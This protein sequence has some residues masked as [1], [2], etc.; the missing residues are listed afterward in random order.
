MKKGILG[1]LFAL[2]VN[3]IF[4]QT[5]DIFFKD[6]VSRTW[7]AEDGIQ[8]NSI[9][10][11]FQDKDGYILFGTYGGLTRFDGVKFLT[12]N[13]IYNKDYK[14]LS[15]RTIFQDSRGNIWVGSN[16]EGAFCI[17][18]E[19]G[20]AEFTT[21]NG[22]PNNSIRSFCEDN[23]GNIWIGTASGIACVSPDLNIIKLPGFDKIPLDNKF[24]TFQL[25][26]DT[27]GRI[28]IV[29]RSEKGLYIY[30]DQTFTVYDGIH[31]VENPV[32]TAMSQDST[33]AFWFG[34]APYYA[35]KVT[36]NKEALHNL[37]SGDQKGTIVTCIYQDSSKNIWFGLDNGITILHDGEYSYFKKENGLSDESVVKIIEDKEKNIWIATDRGGIQKLS[38]GKF[39]TTSMPTT[40]NAIAQDKYR[41]VVWLAGDNGMYCYKDNKLQENEI[42]KYC[43]N[44]RIRHVGVTK[45]N[46]VLVSTYEKF[47]QL[48]FNADGTIDC[49]TKE[50]GL[51]GNRVRVAE[52]MSNGDLYVGTTTGLSIISSKTGEIT[53]I[54]KGETLKN[55]YIMCLYEAADG[56]IWAGTDG[57]GIFIL[58][59]TQIERII[60]KEDFLAG[61]VVFK[62]AGYNNNDIWITTGTGV[63]LYR[64]EKIH[65]FNNSNGFGS[66]GVFQ[67]IPDFSGR[68]WGTSN[69]GIFFVKNSEIEEVIAGTRNAVNIKYFNRLDG[70]TSGGVTSTS[71]SMKDDLGRIWFTLIDGFT[72][73][74]PVRNASKNLAPEVKIEDVYVDSE[75]C[76]AKNNKI[77][78][79]PSAKRLVINYTG[80]SFISSEQLIFRT[81]LSGFENEYTDWSNIRVASYTNLKPGTYEFSVLAQNGDEVISPEAAKI[82]I[83]KK[84][85]LWQRPWFVALIV[86]VILALISWAVFAKIDRLNKEKERTEKLSLEVIRTLVGTI[87][88]KDK[89]TNG[90]S[91]R[92]ADY[93]KMLAAA[94]GL[95]KQMQTEIY[96]SALLHDIGKIGIPD[97]I[98]NKPEQ[99][100]EEEYNI[101]KT[102]P[103]IGS[104]ILSS[105]STMQNISVGARSHHE[106]FDGT[107][108]PDSKK[109]EEISVIARII[110]VAD[111]Y[112]AM[113]SNRSYRHFM[114][115]SDVKEEFIKHKGTQFDPEIADK[116]IEIIDNDVDYLLHE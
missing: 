12:L 58:N 32:V 34:L 62:I 97:T 2:F 28:W 95:D 84:P 63:S 83:E 91:N 5:T 96:Y 6:Y 68:L 99:L 38:Y 53:N 101:I 109:G 85:Y 116:M 3:T 30:A 21:E 111:A 35:V 49:W 27:A 20:V 88:A 87:D 24:I 73:F 44:I 70:I 67:I 18:G 31:S 43:K 54:V 36:G 98:I 10:D 92:V 23:E 80:I 64:D 108:Y 72:I 71:L 90:H 107:G 76:L 105:I 39:Q 22:L 79:Q 17:N 112:D 66:D 115:Q 37:G 89:Y 100:T 110:C 57:G 11:I 77:V 103:E 82:I 86:I 114:K 75:K 61:N 40:I 1:L 14:F 46:A 48:R 94:I 102:H 81:K 41:G 4:A 113:T 42:T 50:T 13:K 9:T 52:Q 19:E 69:R 15:A 26:C 93:S 8:G 55:D 106:H 74:D 47:G 16:D 51:A 60:T 7:N 59:G 78:L 65:T 45:D 33:G 56:K 25:Y 29:T 104:Q